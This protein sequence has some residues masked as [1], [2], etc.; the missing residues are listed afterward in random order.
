MADIFNGVI[1]IAIY[2]CSIWLYQ[3]YDLHLLIPFIPEKNLIVNVTLY[4]S[5]LYIIKTFLFKKI[6]H[7]GIIWAQIGP[8]KDNYGSEIKVIEKQ[9]KAIYLRIAIIKYCKGM[10]GEKLKIEF[11]RGLTCQP[12][13]NNTYSGKEENVVY[14]DLNDI[15]T[16][17]QHVE[18]KVYVLNSKEHISLQSG[19]IIT[20]EKHFWKDISLIY[21]S[22]IIKL[23]GD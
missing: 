12:D 18:L 21:K 10:K 2:L 8:N 16:G 20:I 3:Y 15:N 11:P 9:S 6:I 19:I 22:T 17:T 5:V 13:G 7:E 23:E 1:V 4:S 14:F